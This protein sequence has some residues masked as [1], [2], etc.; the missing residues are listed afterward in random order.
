MKKDDKTS[1]QTAE[2]RR[3][4]EEI[5]RRKVAQLPG[6]LEAPGPEETQQM[7]HELQVHQIEL[8]MQNEE[9]RR[10]QAELEASRVR[11]FDLYDRA[12]VSYCTLSEKGL[13]LEANLT[14]VS[15]LGVPR[16]KLVRQPITRFILPENQ[17]IYYLQ[18]RQLLKTGE[19]QTCELRMA[20]K[21]GTQFWAHMDAT[22][23]EDADGLPVSRVV[24][25][26]ITERKL[27]EEALARAHDDLELRVH[28][29]TAELAQACNQFRTEIVEREQ[30]E[31]HL[32]RVQKIE[33]LGTLAGGIAHD[34]NNLL[35]AILGFTEMAID[36]VP[37]RPSVEKN[38]N[39][40]LKAAMR[41]R[42]LVKQIL[43]FNRKS[44]LARSHVSLSPLVKETVQL[45]RASIPS[46]I[47][48]QMVI[49]ASSDTVLAT[50]DEVHQILMNL[51]TNASI[52]MEE[53]GGIME[54]SFG[55]A[56]FVPDLPMLAPDVV[57]REYVELV[58]KDTGT[59]MSP[60]VM[61]RI[62]DP[63]FTTREV[64][65]GTGMGLAVVYGIV[66]NLQG[67]ITVES[68][69]GIGSTFRV[70]LPKVK[71]EAIEDPFE[72]VQIVGGTEHILFVD[73]EE[74]LVDWGRA[75]LE[76]LG[77]TVT[78]LTDPTE[79]LKTFSAD[80]SRFHLV[81]TD[82]TMPKLT[83]IGLARKILALRPDIPVILCTGHS[84]TVSPEKVKEAGIK[85]FLMKP[86]RRQELARGIRMVLDSG[87]EQ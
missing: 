20:R 38:L 54:I 14:T 19:A 85:K 82:Q 45:L 71:S 69:P 74:L 39:M 16:G 18:H 1:R 31:E 5:A 60:E 59:G 51:A 34:F 80:P 66:R 52:A 41:A 28:E 81:I 8:E 13:I 53:T 57:P 83:G 17:D 46:T 68:R 65:K 44:A 62:F 10:V 29:R 49:G 76:R 55:D 3:R 11:Y 26:D 61:E 58:V 32:R 67:F 47:E 43:S 21:D 4:A 35:A 27:A 79:A 48:I 25:S 40:V 36:D 6:N 63:F 72:T 50:A 75:A 23:V 22:L 77:Y 9:L 78:V 86:V 73:D 87:E 33:A 70:L 7:L 30:A 56:D 37:D 64:G 2:L 12:P 84:V 42:N 15:L 24:I